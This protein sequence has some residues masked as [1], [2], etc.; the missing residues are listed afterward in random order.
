MPRKR[1]Q[2]PK[3]VLLAERIAD[4]RRIIDAQQMLLE[5]LRVAGVSTREMTAPFAPTSVHLRTFWYTNGRRGRLKQIRLKPNSG[6][7]KKS[8]SK[9]PYTS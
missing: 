6:V 3:L 4:T 7:G 1:P 8:I 2:K 9:P 5:K